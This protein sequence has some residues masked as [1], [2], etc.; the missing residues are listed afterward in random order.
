MN[1]GFLLAALIF[2][3]LAVRAVFFRDA[4][5]EDQ[6]K[7]L[8]ETCGPGAG[9]GD[10]AEETIEEHRQMMVPIW[11]L[12]AGVFWVATALSIHG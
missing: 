12:L 4:W 8:D 6:R 3:V 11:I 5:V 7:E 9:E 10:D 2:T 1:Y